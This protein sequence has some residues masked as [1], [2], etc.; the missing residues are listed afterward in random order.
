[1]PLYEYR[2]E[3]C[4]H[5]FEAL[6]RNPITP[7]CPRCGGATLER[8][9]SLFAVSSETTRHTSLNAAKQQNAKIE[10]DRSAA[11]HEAMHHHRH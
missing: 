4:R 10:K 8:L 2:C 11:E 1:M 3:T 6:V 7:Q 5:E 9:L